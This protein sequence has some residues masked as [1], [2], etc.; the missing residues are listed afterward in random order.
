M[1]PYRWKLSEYRSSSGRLAMTDWRKGLPV[2]LPR[3]D[4]D[5][6]LKNMAKLE[7]WTYPDIGSLKGKNNH[8]V[9]ELRWRSGNVPHRILGY[10]R[11]DHEFVMLIGCTHD[12]KKYYPS[13][14][15]ETA[16][17]RR[18]KIQ[19]GEASINEYQLPTH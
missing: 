15:M 7:K 13:G 1:I 18:K 2:G 11:S 16:V 10:M 19:S 9:Y 6:F 12:K 5:T 17:D 14:C 4:M 3:A 8:G